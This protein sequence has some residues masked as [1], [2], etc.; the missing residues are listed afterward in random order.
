MLSQHQ[1]TLPQG[2][3]YSPFD[4]LLT[5]I[6][7]G[8]TMPFRPPFSAEEGAGVR[9]YLFQ[10]R[11]DVRIPAHEGISASGCSSTL[12]SGLR[13]LGGLDLE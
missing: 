11:L 13:S 8:R 3:C 10:W 12:T 5:D 1:S 2:D 4:F 6:L 9:C 7:S